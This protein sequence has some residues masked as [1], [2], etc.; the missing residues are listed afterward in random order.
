MQYIIIFFSAFF[1]TILLTPYL[2]KFLIK[3]NITDNPGGRRIHDTV[4]PRMGGL[5]I[6][7][8]TSLF[9]LTIYNDLNS[10]RL[11]IISNIIIIICGV[12]DD[13]R[14]LSYK[15]KFIFQFISAI[16][17]ILHFSINIVS[18]SLLSFQIPYIIGAILSILF[19]VGA[20]NAINMMDG[21]DGLVSTTSFMLLLIISVIA[22]RQNNSLIFLV[23]LSTLGTVLGFMKFNTYP[24][25][26]FLGDTG[27]YFIALLLITSLFDLTIKSRSGN[28]DL[29]IPALFLGLPVLDTMKV[30]IYRILNGVSPFAADKSHLHHF[31]ISINLKHRYTVLIIQLLYIPFLILGIAYLRNPSIYFIILLIPL[32]ALIIFSP[33]LIGFVLKF[34]KIRIAFKLFQNVLIYIFNSAKK[35]Y[36]FVLMIAPVLIIFTTLPSSSKMDNNYTL[37]FIVIGLLQLVLSIYENHNSG[38]IKHFYVFLNFFFYFLIL[39]TDFFGFAQHSEIALLNSRLIFYI[40]LITVIIFVIFFLLLRDRVI[41]SDTPFFSGIELTIVPLIILFFI[42]GNIINYSIIPFATVS[43]LLAF[44][45]YLAY[46]IYVAISLKY[47]KILFYGSYVPTFAYLILQFI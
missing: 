28:L 24:A 11:L 10:V 23:S 42:I 14:G 40:S 19:L 45:F 34:Q 5:V 16:F 3:Y 37:I 2:I 15:I 7:F 18:F 36:P 44:I 38:N 8:V 22:Y 46:K 1:L 21:L 35:I 20:F 26:I 33:Q 41:P 39:K 12:L 9:F 13:I 32:S 31:F 29:I 27:A 43:F 25:K 4:T 17:I 6:I 47:I 30:M